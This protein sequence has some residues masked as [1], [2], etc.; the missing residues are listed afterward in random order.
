MAHHYGN[1]TAD[2]ELLYEKVS[3]FYKVMHKIL[4]N[5]GP[6]Y[7]PFGEETNIRRLVRKYLKAISCF[8]LRSCVMMST[9]IMQK[10]VPAYV[11]MESYTLVMELAS[12]FETITWP[13]LKAALF[14]EQGDMDMISDDVA[15][16]AMYT[17]DGT[18]EPRLKL[19]S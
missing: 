5:D 7:C 9:C 8:A 16:P 12:R 17:C 14:R 19:A 10:G 11:P 3:G 6:K 1:L 18:E 13:E 15:G 4:K 2:L